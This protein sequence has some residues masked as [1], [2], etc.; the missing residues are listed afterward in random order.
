MKTQKIFSLGAIALLLPHLFCCVLPAVL[1]FLA[2]IAPMNHAAE[3]HFIPHGWE[4]WLLG[5]S[6]VMLGI[7]W[8][9]VLRRCNCDCDNCKERGHRAQKIILGVAT[10]LFVFSLLVHIFWH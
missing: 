4:P 3:F 8:F 1:A 9:L 2:M 6:A 10:T 7:S 5:A